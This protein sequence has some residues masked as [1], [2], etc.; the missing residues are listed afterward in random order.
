[1]FHTGPQLCRAIAQYVE[2]YKTRRFH[3]TLDYPRPDKG[4]TAGSADLAFIRSRSCCVSNL[5]SLTES[6]KK[7][8]SQ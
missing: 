8:A 7:T 1:M 4:V 5:L 6:E 3:Q 2:F